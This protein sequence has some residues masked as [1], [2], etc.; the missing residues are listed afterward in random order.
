M[1]LDKIKHYIGSDLYNFWTAQTSRLKISEAA[2]ELK[3]EM[4]SGLLSGVRYT[5]ELNLLNYLLEKDSGCNNPLITSGHAE[6]I[7][8][9][10]LF[11]TIENITT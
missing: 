10:H 6:A 7:E 8:R 3:T 11:N 2:K 9:T 4:E 5:A 1:T